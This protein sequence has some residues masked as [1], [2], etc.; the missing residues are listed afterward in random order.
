MRQAKGEKGENC[1]LL[2]VFE[3]DALNSYLGRKRGNSLEQTTALDGF[4]DLCVELGDPYLES[5]RLATDTARSVSILTHVHMRYGFYFSSLL[6]RVAW[7]VFWVKS[8]Y[9]NSGQTRIP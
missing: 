9:F 1:G 2:L 3:E 5:G 7:Y 8:F 4:L 6:L